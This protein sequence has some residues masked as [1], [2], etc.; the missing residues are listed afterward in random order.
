MGP[1][2]L[3]YAQQDVAEYRITRMEDIDGQP[4]EI[5]YF[6]YFVKDKDGL[7]KLNQM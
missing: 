1:I 4:Q 2:E 6:I 7:W 5:S 3:D